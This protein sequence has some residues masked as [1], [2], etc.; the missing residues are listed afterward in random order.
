[1]NNTIILLILSTLII[2]TSG[3][4]TVGTGN[5]IIIE[6]FEPDFTSV[7]IDE[8]VSFQVKIRNSGSVDSE[9]GEIKIMGLD[10]NKWGS[11]K[12][13]EM[14]ALLGADPVYGTDGETWTHIFKYDKAPEV[15]QGISVTYQPTARLTYE[16]TSNTIKSITVASQNEL[17]NTQNLGNPLPSE[18]VSTSSSPVAI[19]IISKGPIRFWSDTSSVTFPLEIK[20]DNVGGGVVCNNYASC[21]DTD[22]WNKI[23]LDYE[24]KGIDLGKCLDGDIA[25]FK[26]QTNTLTCKATISD[27]PDAG[28]L[29]KTI[30]IEARY[31]YFVDKATSITVNWR[32]RS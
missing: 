32:E 10:K 20:I 15:P 18:T 26:G 8:P 2:L 1:M 21:G 13:E 9:K 17:R 30:K 14:G 4:T 29:Q 6:V 5:G 25:L 27:L 3:C 31:G 7:F 28:I 23:E 22:S 19:T 24:K 16:Y 12:S 11:E